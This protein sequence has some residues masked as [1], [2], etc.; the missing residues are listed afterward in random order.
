MMTENKMPLIVQIT[1]PPPYIPLLLP[2]PYEVSV[3]EPQKCSEDRPND[4]QEIVPVN[5][6][7]VINI[8]EKQHTIKLSDTDIDMITRKLVSE[9][10]DQL[11]GVDGPPGPPGPPGSSAPIQDITQLTTVLNILDARL[12]RLE[13]RQASDGGWV[14]LWLS[15]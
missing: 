6:L 5:N 7:P 1:E 2:P 15:I 13:E 3:Q 8:E 14:R 11:L 10:K 9:H 12:E 4:I